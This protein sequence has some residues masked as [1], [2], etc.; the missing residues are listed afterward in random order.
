MHVSITIP[1]K[2]SRHTPAIGLIPSPMNEIKRIVAFIA[3][4]FSELSVIA[5]T[6]KRFCSICCATGWISA[7]AYL[8][9]DRAPGVNRRGVGLGR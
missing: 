5:K 6:P 8:G 3:Y 7:G 4:S 9:W 1:L 2:R